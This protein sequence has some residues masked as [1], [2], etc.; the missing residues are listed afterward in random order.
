MNEARESVALCPG[1]TG[2]GENGKRL[3]NWLTAVYTHFG[4]TESGLK[5]VRVYVSG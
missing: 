1:G 4:P 3:R 5:K 2:R